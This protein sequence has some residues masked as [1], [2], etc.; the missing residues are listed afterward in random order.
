MVKRPDPLPVDGST[1]EED[2]SRDA[3]LSPGGPSLDGPSLD[4][5]S[6]DGANRIV[7]PSDRVELLQAIPEDVV[8]TPR[9]LALT[10]FQSE[11]VKHH[12]NVGQ[13]CGLHEIPAQEADWAE[14]PEA[15]DPRWR[16][17]LKEQGIERLYRHQE[18]SIS[19]AL[20]RK[21]VL[22]VSSTASGKTLC[23][24]IP[25]LED[26]LR[27]KE[28]YALYLFP[29]K[30]L[31][32][33]QNR[34]LSEMISRLG[35]EVEAGVFDGDTEPTVRKRLKKKGRIILTNPDMLHQAILPHHGGWVGLFS[36]LSTVVIDEVHSLRGIFGS[37][38]A[39]VLRRL[40]R[41]A[42]HYGASPRFLCA[43]ATVSNPA[44]HAER[45]IGEPV[46]VVDEDGSPRGKKTIVLWNPPL[47]QRPD[48]TEGRKGPV[49]VATRLLP[50][51]LRREIRTICFASARSTV[52]LI[53][54]YV[55]DKLKGNRTTN[56][57]ASKLE[58]YRAGYLPKERREIEGRLFSGDL[59]GV[60]STNALELGI[61]IGGLDACL[62]VGYPGS[63]ASFLQRSGRAGRRA[64]SS[65]VVFIAR[66]EPIDQFFMR[67]PDAF[68]GRSPENA[69]IEPSNPYIL[70]KH[71][72]CAAYELPLSDADAEL[73]GEDLPGVLRLLAEEDRLRESDGRWYYVDRNYPAKDVKLRT[74]HDENFTIYELN[75]QEIVGELDYVAALMSLY[76]GAVYIHRSETHIVEELDYENQIARIRKGE[77]GYYT[78][79]LEQKRVTVDEEFETGEW[80][81][82]RLS[83]GEVTVETRITGFK[84]VRF[85]TVENIGYGDVDLPPIL[86]E[87][88]AL[89]ID[90]PEEMAKQAMKFGSDF[91][92]SG[93]QG[94]G[95]LYSS[96]M[97]FFVM[98]D[99]GD[100]DYFLDGRRLYFYDLYPGGIGY[101]EKAYEIFEK[102]LEATLEHL[103]QCDCKAGCPSCVLPT[104]TRYEIASE[105]TIKEFPFPKEA[106]RY[107]LHLLLQLEL[108]EPQLAPIE[109][110]AAERQVPE[111]PKLDAKTV[112]KV[113]RALKRIK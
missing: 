113:K 52:E 63:V 96:L 55:W 47:F 67:H 15:L 68:F 25:V 34:V 3:G 69:I 94:I 107:F 84:K 45:L 89:Y 46:E 42:A 75:A 103:K 101:S 51:L 65:L 53:L 108:Y 104:S 39:S 66:P 100:I 73:F 78:Q 62:L 56:S 32:Q 109:M 33:D 38:V 64:Q 8:D 18:R 106:A 85:H 37:N 82:C 40:R 21:N 83:L 49:S 17:Y 31:A 10:R 93:L 60:V 2:R 35:L 54:R 4:G 91:F 59:L 41:I 12:R 70:T 22:T 102:I 23:Y 6:L 99:P 92:H 110:P 77:T 74:V 81:D 58:A 1:N 86:L 98:A 28:T 5:P 72:I 14:I 36:G 24:N 111:P 95:R 9:G 44:E 20:E 76:E 88:V 105:P 50:E 97:P 48:G 29:T 30:A 26:F 7:T 11:V 80:R 87:T 43:S 61:D 71:L 79:A 19:L 27:E 57:L 13:I 90:I 112:G 16:E